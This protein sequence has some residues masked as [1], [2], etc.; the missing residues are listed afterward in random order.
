MNFLHNFLRL[1]IILIQKKTDCAVCWG[2]MSVNSTIVAA[3]HGRKAFDKK[4]L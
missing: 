3:K 2:K 1:A 4:L